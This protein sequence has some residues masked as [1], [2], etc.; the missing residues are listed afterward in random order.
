[1]T[2]ADIALV[3]GAI[4]VAALVA[5]AVV[6][7]R[8]A[9]RIRTLRARIRRAIPATFEIVPGPVAAA[10]AWAHL[11]KGWFGARVISSTG[12]KRRALVLRR[13]LWQ[14]VDRASAAVSHAQAADAPLGE[15]PRLVRQL[16]DLARQLDRQLAFL[17]PNT[18]GNSLEGARAETDQITR[19]A[20]EIA[21]A[22]LDALRCIPNFDSDQVASAIQREVQAVRAGFARLNSTSR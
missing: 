2:G 6:S 20:D 1:M 7:W 14:H 17:T 5:L 3:V 15:L 9:R 13:E 16:G 21:G 22:A 4:G 10:T 18:A 19:C 12:S 11:R 8:V